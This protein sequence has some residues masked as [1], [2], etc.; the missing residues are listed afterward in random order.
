MGSKRFCNLSLC[1]TLTLLLLFSSPLRLV[2]E[3]KGY[4][5]EGPMSKLNRAYEFY[6]KGEY[7]K[8]RDLERKL[9]QKVFG[10]SDS[11][12][13][14]YPTSVTLNLKYLA[15][16]LKDKEGYFETIPS[17]TGVASVIWAAT[18]G[19]SRSA[20]KKEKRILFLTG[21][22]SSRVTAMISITGK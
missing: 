2:A 8:A 16:L 1:S 15:K 13:L 11:G 9:R 10:E 12:G 5:Y 7:Q 19:I 18:T 17:F 22:S 14:E 21:M 3:D 4:D 20:V 6:D